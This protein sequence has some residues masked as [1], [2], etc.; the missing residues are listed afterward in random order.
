MLKFTMKN[1]GVDL[2]KYASKYYGMPEYYFNWHSFNIIK[3]FTYTSAM[4]SCRVK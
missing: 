4:Y 2:V 3:S 1:S